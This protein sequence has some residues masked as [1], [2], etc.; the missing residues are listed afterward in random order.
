VC[1]AKTNQCGFAV[2]DGPCTT[3]AECIMGSCDP[4][5]EICVPPDAGVDAG[6]DAASEA[7]AGCKEDSQCGPGDFCATTEVCTP[8]LPAGSTCDRAAECLGEICAS[9]VCSYIVSSGNGLCSVRAPGSSGDARDSGAIGLLLALAGL[10]YRRRR[11]LLAKT[12]Y[13]VGAEG[14]N[15]Q[16]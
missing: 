5:T 6:H 11:S 7:G 2:G 4:T 3:S 16:R 15:S 12:S 14:T 8:R 1:D 10:G 9:G 13:A